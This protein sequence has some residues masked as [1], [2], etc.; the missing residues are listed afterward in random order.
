MGEHPGQTNERG[1]DD[2]EGVGAHCRHADDGQ[3]HAEDDAHDAVAAHHD[4]VFVESARPRADAGTRQVD[5]CVGGEADDEGEHHHPLA[6]EV[7]GGDQRAEGEHRQDDDRQ[8]DEAEAAD[9]G[10][11]GA[12]ALADRTAM[13][14]RP[15]E[16]LLEGEEETGARA[17]DGEPQR[18]DRA[19]LILAT[20]APT[21]RP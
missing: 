19:E 12:A 3:H 6:V 16:L 17:K 8:Q 11:D 2:G 13:G 15:A 7:V 9:L 1:K 20:D 21:C 18:R 14:E 5:G 4:G 10:E